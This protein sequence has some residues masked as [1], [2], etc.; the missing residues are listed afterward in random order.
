MKKSSTSWRSFLLLYPMLAL[1]P[2]GVLVGY[3]VWT[4]TDRL[5]EAE[6]RER[7]AVDLEREAVAA[8]LQAVATDLCVLAQQNELSRL[9]LGDNTR[10]TRLAIAAEYLALARNAKNYDQ[11]RYLD[12]TGQE[13]VRV[14]NNGG[15]PSIVASTKLQNKA[16]RYY[17][18]ES[19]ALQPGQIYVSPLDLNIEHGQVEIPYKPMIRLGTPVQDAAGRLRGAVLIN[20][21]AQE[22]IDQVQIAGTVSPGQPMMLN[23][24]GYWL[25]AS[26][27]PPPSWGFMFPG[28]VDDRMATYYPEVWAKMRATPSGVIHAEA[29]IFSYVRYDPL[30]GISG[31]FECIDH[32]TGAVSRNGYP[33]ILASYLPRA[34]IDQWRRAIITEALLIGLPVLILLAIGTHALLLVAGERRRH[35]E[36]LEALARFDTLT[37]LANRTTFE[38]RLTEDIA[39]AQRHPCRLAVLYLDLDGF[40][41]INDTLGHSAGDEVLRQVAQ[42]LKVN[43]RA[44]DLAAR[45]GGDEFAVL[46]TD[47]SDADAALG[48]AENIRARVA[49]LPW[50]HLGVSIGVALWPDDVSANDAP[51]ADHR[52]ATAQ[53]LRLAD[54][55]MYAAKTAGK[56]RISRAVPSYSGAVKRDA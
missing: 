39:R 15:A 14:N 11:I 23:D 18:A 26:E 37:G 21:L 40:K 33:W 25:V 13:I 31:C 42:V 36:Q 35:R 43:S 55:A 12:E 1:I 30:N 20:F 32:Q 2:I 53:L 9:L 38:E 7:F 56:N 29:G 6:R 52:Q 19:M 17:V 34:L 3:G 8:Q 54:Q 50:D 16:N 41:Q 45:H 51:A 24:Q 46:L 28:Q 4:F 49:R 5:Q 10:E 27:P 22:M 47:V 48:V 44:T